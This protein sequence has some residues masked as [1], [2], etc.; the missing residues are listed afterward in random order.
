MK[1]K[2]PARKA[3]PDFMKGIAVVLMIQ[4]H[5]TELFAVSTFSESLAG[6]ISLFLGGVPAAPLFMAVMG[7][8]IAAN[9]GGLK[10]QFKRGLKLIGWGFLLNIG[11]NFHLFLKIFSGKFDLDPLP[12]FFGVDILFLAGLSIII[13]AALRVALNKHIAAWLAVALIAAAA[14]KYLP[15]PDGAQPWLT[16][17]LSYFY[18]LS[19]W[20]YFPVLPWLAY[21]IFGFVFFLIYHEFD[22]AVIPIKKKLGFAG[23]LLVIFLLTFRYGLSVSAE[24]TA[25]YHHGLIFTLWAVMFLLLLTI[26]FSLIVSLKGDSLA[27]K[28]LKWV[29]RYVTSFYVIQWL[30]IGNMATIIY[31]SLELPSLIFSFILITAATSLLVWLWSKKSVFRYLG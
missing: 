3:L 21:P 10:R 17:V 14:G 16:Y 4:V 12:Y 15:S 9:P 29:G 30:L 26:M 22:P 7:W 27:V 23:I 13:I 28:Y 25:Y 2:I 19:W 1:S 18:G 11:M 8:F 20:S 6:R 24:L 31:K 5:L